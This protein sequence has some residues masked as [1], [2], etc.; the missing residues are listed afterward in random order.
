MDNIFLYEM[1]ESRVIILSLD[2]SL[3]STGFSII[4]DEY[5]L[6]SYGT[7]QTKAKD[8]TEEERLYIIGKKIDE[9]IK[10]YRITN[11]CVEGSY[12]SVN[13]K[14]TQQLAKLLG[15]S[16]FLS[17]DNNINILT[18][19]PTTARKSIIGNGKADKEE[20]AKYIQD[21]Y[22]NIGE[23]SDKQ[24]KAVQKT[25]DIYDSMLL[26]LYFLKKNNLNNKYGN[27]K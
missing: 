7:I 21:N 16:I 4:D 8:N 1:G 2:L 27:N 23:F 10:E 5:N 26:G 12:K 17:V 9:I 25:S 15:I 13:I 24:T 19:N 18:V 11:I 20:V 22:W 14:T 3:S 6:I